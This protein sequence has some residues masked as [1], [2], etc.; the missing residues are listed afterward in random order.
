MVDDLA[1][2]VTTC[3]ASSHTLPRSLISSSPQDPDL[4]EAAGMLQQALNAET[5]QEEERLWTEVR[6]AG[7]DGRGPSGVVQF[8]G[9]DES[10]EGGGG[11]GVQE[12][13][14]LWT[15]VAGDKGTIG[16]GGVEGAAVRE[17][18]AERGMGAGMLQQALNA[19]IV[20][21]E[22]RLWTEVGAS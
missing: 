16:G 7:G 14:R 3:T 2:K 15:E 4:R 9:E 8:K 1:V 10:A 5:V 21:E 6:G 13:E 11:S 22:E 12:E 17:E 19:E 18:V 20:Q